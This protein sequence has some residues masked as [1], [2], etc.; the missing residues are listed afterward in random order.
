[1][2]TFS[3]G[4]LVVFHPK[5]FKGQYAPWYDAYLGRT[6]EVVALH[7]E[8]T[9]VELRDVE[10]VIMVAGYVHHD[11]LVPASISALRQQTRQSR[12]TQTAARGGS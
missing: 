6:F 1:M 5:V 11:E 12:V 7:Y 2:D 10:R 9:H 4:D 3:A 8:D